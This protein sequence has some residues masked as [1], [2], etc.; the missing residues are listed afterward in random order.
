MTTAAI[1]VAAGR[2][3]RAGGDVPKQWRQVAGRTVAEHSVALFAAHPRVD[4][5]VLVIAA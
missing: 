1:I 2:G 3:V 5:V 4:E